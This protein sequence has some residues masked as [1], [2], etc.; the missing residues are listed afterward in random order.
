MIIIVLFFSGVFLWT[1]RRPLSNLLEWWNGSGPYDDDNDDDDDDD[2]EEQDA[3]RG[4]PRRRRRRQRKGA[5]PQ[6]YETTTTTST[7]THPPS[8]SAATPPFSLVGDPNSS[9]TTSRILSTMAHYYHHHQQHQPPSTA[10]TTTNNNT[11]SAP[12]MFWQHLW[13]LSH[14]V[15][16]HASNQYSPAFFAAYQQMKQL[17]TTTTTTTTTNTNTNRTTTPVGAG[18]G[19]PTSGTYTCLYYDPTAGSGRVTFFSATQLHFEPVTTWRSQQSSSQQQPFG[20]T[21]TI[22][23]QGNDSDGRFVIVEG[24]AAASGD[25]YWLEQQPQPQQSSSSSLMMMAAT[26]HH[27]YQVPQG[28]GR[29]L[30]HCGKLDFHDDSFTGFW[31][32]NHATRSEERHYYEMRLHLP[33]PLA[34]QK[35]HAKVLSQQHHE[36]SSTL[37]APTAPRTSLNHAVLQTLQ[38]NSRHAKPYRISTPAPPP[39]A[40][41]HRS[42]NTTTPSLLLFAP[43]NGTYRCSYRDKGVVHW[44]TIRLHFALEQHHVVKTTTSNHDNNN[45]NN[46]TPTAE[47]QQPQQPPSDESACWIWRV[48]GHG[49]VSPTQWFSPTRFTIDHGMVSASTGRAY[50]VER[51]TTFIMTSRHHKE[52]AVEE[53]KEEVRGVDDE[54]DNHHPNPKGHGGPTMST[55]TTTTRSAPAPEPER[56]V[57][58]TGSFSFLVQDFVGWRQSNNDAPSERYQ[59]F[60]LL[61]EEQ[62]QQ[63]QQQQQQQDNNNNSKD[64]TT[65]APGGAYQVSYELAKSNVQYDIQASR[66][67]AAAASASS[68]SSTTGFAVY[69]SS[70]NMANHQRRRYYTP[71]SGSYTFSY[72][73]IANATTGGAMIQFQDKTGQLLSSTVRLQFQEISEHANDNA[74]G[75]QASQQ[76]QSQQQDRSSEEKSS[77]S[78]SWKITGSGHN[79]PDGSEFTIVEGLVS[80]SGKAYWVQQT[81]RDSPAPNGSSPTTTT[82]TTTID[83]VLATGEFVFVTP[84]SS[85][86]NR[87]QR[88]EPIMEFRGGWHDGFGHK[89]WYHQ[90]YLTSQSWW[91]IPGGGSGGGSSGGGGGGGGGGQRPPQPQGGGGGGGGGPMPHPLA[92]PQPQDSTSSAAAMTAPGST[93]TVASTHWT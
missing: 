64:S 43:T 33:Y 57:L 19:A 90:F 39:L 12:T 3:H 31:M 59:D 69:S 65:T 81:R 30:L 34:L 5:G 68:S 17:V 79:A 91:Y 85:S 11:T 36:E 25:V 49:H 83:W 89:R 92:E 29:L 80:A 53:V 10:S 38:W 35:A 27:H 50:W 28:G 78:C 72:H 24:M 46:N 20:W 76:P 9:S 23:G 1:V 51:H 42:T 4:K 48:T 44:V 26:P 56:L 13:S 14:P 66:M 15:V 61:Y 7:T 52:V 21:W 70:S 47:Q 93:T 22:T 77:N 74:D 41:Q 88:Q 58:T 84:P 55:T 63:Q 16:G 8:H 32:A 2:D 40:W 37:Y 73:N 60:S 87:L 82:T 67:M 75:G 18:G 45:N 6:Y 71:M 54:E 62:E 86:P